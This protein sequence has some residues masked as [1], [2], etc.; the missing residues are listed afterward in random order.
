[1]S[2]N[3]GMD[4]ED[5]VHIHIGILLNQSK[6]QNN[7]FCSNVE[8]PRDCLT[9]GIQTK[10]NTIWYHLYVEPQRWYKSTYLW[11]R[12]RITKIENR[13]VAAKWEGEGEGK[14]WQFVISRCKP[15]H[16]EWINKA[17]LYSTGNCIQY[18]L[19]NANGREYEKEIHTHTH[20]H[21]YNSVTLMYSS[22]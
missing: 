10:T 21:I 11:N 2:I 1:M 12:N 15:L 14:D 4:K 20:T 18:L 17:P 8:G 3:R 6:E 16:V 19:T 9:E 7:G 13:L 22:N 5:V